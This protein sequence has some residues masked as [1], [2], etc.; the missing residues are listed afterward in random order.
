MKASVMPKLSP[1]KYENRQRENNNK[2]GKEVGKLSL[3]KSEILFTIDSI[4]P[5]TRNV[6]YS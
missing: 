3:I 2:K 6:C 1:N 5:L 4:Y